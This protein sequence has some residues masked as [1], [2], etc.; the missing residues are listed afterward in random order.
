[1]K[2][3]IYQV[4]FHKG[5]HLQTTNPLPVHKHQ[6]C[7]EILRFPDLYNPVYRLQYQIVQDHP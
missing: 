3:N 2:S 5:I 7:F 4:T 1:M 6:L